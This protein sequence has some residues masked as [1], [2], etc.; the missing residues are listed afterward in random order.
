MYFSV[1]PGTNVL[2]DWLFLGLSCVSLETAAKFFLLLAVAK[3]RMREK[4]NS[5][6][7]GLGVFFQKNRRCFQRNAISSFEGK[8]V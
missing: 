4:L 6:E 3:M 5:F 7:D 8:T 1:I 2:C